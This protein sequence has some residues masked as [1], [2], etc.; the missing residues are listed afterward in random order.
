MTI[1]HFLNSG[2]LNFNTYLGTH[3]KRVIMNRLST[4]SK[5]ADALCLPHSSAY[6]TEFFLSHN[7]D[8]KETSE[9]IFFFSVTE[10]RR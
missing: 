8:I 10:M 5:G 6:K 7:P 1:C 3:K 4:Y 2:D 9:N